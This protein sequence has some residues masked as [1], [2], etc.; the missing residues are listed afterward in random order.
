M[1]LLTIQS[2]IAQGILWAV[3][4]VGVYLTYRILDVADLTVEGTFPLG[5]AVTVMLINAGMNPFLATFIAVLCGAVAGLCTGVLHTVFKI[6]A[7][8]S[9]ILTMIALYSVNIRI[10]DDK[11]TV[12]IAGNSV[13]HIILKL[14]PA[15]MNPN[16]A[17]IIVGVIVSAV[18]IA[19]L[20]LFFGTE[21]G[22]AI[23]ATGSNMKMARAL[24][25]NTD[26]MINPRPHD[27]KCAH[28]AFRQPYR[29]V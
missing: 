10:M 9:G 12:A 7:I 4:T 26:W 16:I 22:C 14:F 27:L 8:L 13:K 3:L 18:L 29:T 24:G 19:L 23:R 6:P 28:C 15:N 17:T 1:N 5:A 2:G 21:L 25:I 11:A 20:Y